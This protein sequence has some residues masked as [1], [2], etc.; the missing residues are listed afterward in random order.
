MAPLLTTKLYEWSRKY[1]NSLENRLGLCCED[2]CTPCI[3][4]CQ[5]TL[6]CKSAFLVWVGPFQAICKMICLPDLHIQERWLHRHGRG[7]GGCGGHE[8]QLSRV[9]RH[10]KQAETGTHLHF[11]FCSQRVCLS[12]SLNCADQREEIDRTFLTP[13]P[14]KNLEFYSGLN[15]F[16]QEFSPT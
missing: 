13:I 15:C 9:R 16:I 8:Y 6:G 11:I 12:V 5:C 14:G 10:R 1:P 7:R 3:P 4:E 2:A